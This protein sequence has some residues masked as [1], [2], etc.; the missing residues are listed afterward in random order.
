MGDSISFAEI[1]WHAEYVANGGWNN[2]VLDN[3][4]APHISY[5]GKGLTY[6]TKIGTTWVI[7]TVDS[8]GNVGNYNSI[9]VDKEGKP[10]I[11]YYD[12]TNGDLKYAKKDSLWIIEKVDTTGDVGRYSS[13]YLNSLGHPCI[14]YCDYTQRVLKYAKK[15][16]GMWQIQVVDTDTSQFSYCSLALDSYDNPHIAYVLDGT[17]PFLKYAYFYGGN[18]QI[19]K[20]SNG[21]FL[22]YKMEKVTLVLDTYDKPY[23]SYTGL[24][25]PSADGF[26]ECIIRDSNN[27]LSVWSIGDLQNNEVFPNSIALEQINDTLYLHIIYSGHSFFGLPQYYTSYSKIRINPLQII[28]SEYVDSTYM[29]QIYPRCLCID[30]LNRPHF[31]LDHIYYY[32]GEYVGVE[33]KDSNFKHKLTVEQPSPNPF[34][35]YITIT[36]QIPDSRIQSS[37]AIIRIYDGAGRLVRTFNNL[38]TQ[39]LNQITWDGKD[40]SGKKVKRGI[41]F[42]RLEGDNLFPQIKKIIYL[43]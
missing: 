41:Y 19:E 36:F 6:A 24:A 2:I 43:R 38:S 25:N 8:I 23:I 33:E 26:A 30:S 27:W 5:I 32:H 11:S 4:G 31:T 7:D 13:L 22:C 15:D 18:W 20:V 40:E 21:P 16:G 35:N 14:V 29:Y 34:T 10:H 39:S 3:N 37:E 9:K 17:P 28:I 42:C 1:V 12:T